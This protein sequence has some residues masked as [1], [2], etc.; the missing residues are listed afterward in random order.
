MVERIIKKTK[1]FKE[2]EE[3][4]NNYILEMSSK[5]SKIRN[6]E[7]DKKILKQN[8]KGTYN[9]KSNSRRTSK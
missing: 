9:E 1:Y 8:L 4:N 6:I 7:R 5:Q 3:E 2:L